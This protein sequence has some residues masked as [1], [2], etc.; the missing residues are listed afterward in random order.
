MEWLSEHAQL[1]G[2]GVSAVTAVVWLVYLQLLLDGMR[3]QRRTNIEITR[4]GGQKENAKCLVSNMGAEP[5]FLL[6]VIVSA[7]AEGETYSA[8]AT[9]RRDSL[10]N[11]CDLREMTNEGPLETGKSRDVGSFEDLV[12]R[13]LS[14]HD[15][16]D[17]KRKIE[18]I[19]I[20]VAVNSGFSKQISAAEQSFSVS[21]DQNGCLHLTPEHVTTR[22]L[23]GRKVRRHIRERLERILDAEA[24]LVR[25]AVE[26]A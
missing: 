22:Q 8:A 4:A 1:L 17:L 26:R 10:E 9:Q 24:D 16:D 7:E 20:L 14:F 25:K 12:K 2:V 5:V 13:L 3:R 19:K 21:V 15:V 18:H 6:S 11:L 23:R